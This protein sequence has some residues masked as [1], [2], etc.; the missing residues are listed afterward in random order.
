MRTLN[1]SM[2]ISFLCAGVFGPGIGGSF[3]SESG[4]RRS[5]IRLMMNNYQS[6]VHHAALQSPRLLNPR[7]AHNENRFSGPD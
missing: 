6:E 4:L 7:D 5:L 2:E 3:E 1:G